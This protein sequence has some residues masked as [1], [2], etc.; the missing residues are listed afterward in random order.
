MSLLRQDRS[1]SS[2]GAL[3]PS[4]G[5][6]YAIDTYVHVKSD[7]VESVAGGVYFFNP[8]RGSLHPVAPESAITKDLHHHQNRVVHGASAFTLFFVFDST[9]T[10]PLYGDAA[11]G[12]AFTEAGMM[13]ATFNAGVETLALGL[14]PV[15][16]VDSAV[17]RLALKFGSE[18]KL[19]LVA[20]CGLKTGAEPANPAP[21]S[22]A[23]LR[24][25]LSA[26][27]PEYMV[28]SEFAMI[29]EVPL[30]P[31]N[32]VDRAALLK[33]GSARS[34]ELGT[35][36]VA[37]SNDLETNLIELWKRVIHVEKVGVEDNFFDLGGDSMA[38]AEVNRFLLEE[39][40]LEV[41]MVKLFQHP[42]VRSLAQFL[43]QQ[44]VTPSP[45]AAAAISE[46][47]QQAIAWL[48]ANP[49]HP[50]AWAVASKLKERGISL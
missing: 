9:V 3:Y 34:L 12:L 2:G 29:E 47:D 8:L 16:L 22:V 10:S 17:A 50:R 21:V 42:T 24:G 6:L 48:K 7:R 26:T 32:K 27:L 19:V 49:A 45:Q 4:A 11:E 31:N 38:V 43:G 15:G 35:R 36:F 37:A 28:P 40:K 20:E 41:P 5:G 14:C 39:W 13:L 1:Q 23:D 30:T 25:F 44:R 46:L 18:Q 33:S